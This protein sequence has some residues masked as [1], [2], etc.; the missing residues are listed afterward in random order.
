MKL[1]ARAIELSL[2]DAGKEKYD[3]A[4]ATVAR[5]GSGSGGEVDL[6]RPTE[7]V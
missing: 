2:R 4:S 3:M 1:C 7:P 6:Q 5:S